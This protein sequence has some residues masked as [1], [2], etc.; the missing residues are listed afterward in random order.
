MPAAEVTARQGRKYPQRIVLAG[1]VITQRRQ[2]GES[3]SRGVLE[4]GS[5]GE[6]AK[7]QNRRPNF[8]KKAGAEAT[9]SDVK[10]GQDSGK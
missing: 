2:L 7:K 9:E 10:N 5:L 8:Q 3:S 1:N 6:G 4:L